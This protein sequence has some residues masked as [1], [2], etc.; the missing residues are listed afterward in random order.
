MS[1]AHDFFECLPSPIPP[2]PSPFKC[3]GIVSLNFT[4]L[5]NCNI[6]ILSLM[7]SKQ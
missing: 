6:V 2:L 5:V 3:S 1:A 7:H 4:K